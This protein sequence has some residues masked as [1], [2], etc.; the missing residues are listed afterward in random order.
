[1]KYRFGRSD[2]WGIVLG[3]GFIGFIRLLCWLAYMFAKATG[4]C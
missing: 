3:L 4:R 2:F 1:M